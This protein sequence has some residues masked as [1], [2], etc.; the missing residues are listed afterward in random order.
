M[1]CAGLFSVEMQRSDGATLIY[2]SES[3]SW[4]LAAAA[5]ELS[6]PEFKSVRVVSLLADSPCRITIHGKCRRCGQYQVEPLS[7]SGRCRDCL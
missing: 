5:A 3:P 7:S 1:P 4:T 2:E 6:N